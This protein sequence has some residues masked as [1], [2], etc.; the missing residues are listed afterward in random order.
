MNEIIKEEK[1]EDMIYGIRR[2]QVIL[3]CKVTARKCY[4]SVLNKGIINNG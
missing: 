1:I 3:D 2:E 4:N